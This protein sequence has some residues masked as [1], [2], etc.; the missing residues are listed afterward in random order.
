MPQNDGTGPVGIGPRDGRGH[1]KRGRGQ[2]SKE[3]GAG[4]KAGGEKGE[5]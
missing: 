4:K 1:D 5:C 3:T 2:S